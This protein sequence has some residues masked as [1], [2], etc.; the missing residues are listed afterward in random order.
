MPLK[1]YKPT[2]PGQRDLVL[3][4]RSELWSGRPE[5]SLSFGLNKKGGRNNSGRITMRRKGGG[6]KRLYRLIDFKRNKVD[7]K[8]TVERIEYDPN[9]SAFIALVKYEDGEKSYI[10]APQRIKVSDTIISSSSSDIKPGNAMPFTGMPIGTIVHNVELKKGKGGQIAR[11]AGSYAQFV[12]RD[13][14]YAQ[15]RLSSGEMRL[16]RQECMATVGAVSNPDNSNQNFGKAGRNRNKGIR[17]SVRGVVMNPI[18]HP[19]GGGEGRTSGGRHPS[20]PWGVPTKGAKTRTN[21]STDKYILRSR[22]KRKGRK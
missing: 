14:N 4:D 15:L 3:V 16:V 20:T 8:G 10:L 13:G 12:G 17:P 11:A 1:S 18:D 2:T 21:K 9:R 7:V 5:K 19:H 22:H 6:A